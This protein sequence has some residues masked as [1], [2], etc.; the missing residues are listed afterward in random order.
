MAWRLRIKH[1]TGYSYAG[2]VK[3]SYNEAR[4]TPLTDS[5]QTTLESRLEISP[6]AGTHR[7]R[8]YWGTEVTSFDLHTPHSEL[9]VTA[10]SLVETGLRRIVPA[11]LDWADL[12]GERVQDEYAEWLAQTRRTDPDDPGSP[13]PDRCPCSG[14]ARRLHPARPRPCGRR[15]STPS[16]QAEGA[17]TR[18]LTPGPIRRPR[19]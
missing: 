3:S 2:K 15:P 10:T 1:R 19:V 12:R 7:Y 11:G 5:T 16:R 6:P 17:V 18:P 14:G 4:M 9:E 8:D 13:R